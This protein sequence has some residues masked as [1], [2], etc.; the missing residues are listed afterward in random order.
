[1]VHHEQK[2]GEEKTSPN[3]FQLAVCW[4]LL[5]KRIDHLLLSIYELSVSTGKVFE[6]FNENSVLQMN[7]ESSRS[8]SFGEFLNPKKF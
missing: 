3:V 2:K 6:V 4:Q 5:G 1:M 7:G 8:V